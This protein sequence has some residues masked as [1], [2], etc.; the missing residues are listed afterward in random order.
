[1]AT[2]LSFSA[3]VVRR[4][5]GIW[6]EG[7]GLFRKFTLTRF[8]LQLQTIHKPG[9]KAEE[10]RA[11]LCSASG[12]MRRGTCNGSHC[13]NLSNLPESL[14]DYKAAGWFQMWP[15]QCFSSISLTT[16]GVVVAGTQGMFT[17][18]LRKRKGTN[19]SSD[20]PEFLRA[21]CQANVR[22]CDT[23]HFVIS[24]VTLEKCR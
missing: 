14:G 16:L 13:S 5:K 20:A 24:D 23:L 11:F 17:H 22:V 18:L 4:K 9:E 2:E 8:W 6:R 1:M 19:H 15:F 21:G 3:Y 12:V 7:W 10:L